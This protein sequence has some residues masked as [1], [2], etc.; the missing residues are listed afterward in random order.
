[1]R[2]ISFLVAVQQFLAKSEELL[3]MLN[4]L[5]SNIAGLDAEEDPR[6]ALRQ[7]VFLNAILQNEKAPIERV[8]KQRIVFFVQHITQWAANPH[9]QLPIQTES[10]KALSSVIGH[11]KDMYG[12]HWADILRATLELWER[13]PAK[14]DGWLSLLHASL[15]LFGTLRSLSE[16]EDAN[17]DLLD[18]WNERQPAAGEELVSVLKSLGAGRN[19]AHQPQRIVNELLA[20]QISK[21]RLR[22][23]EDLSELF[24]LIQ[25]QS[26]S[27]QKTA[28]A[29]LDVQI[30]A[31]QE[32]VSFDAALDKKAARLPEE[33]VSMILEV[34]FM[35]DLGK[36]DL[37]TE[38]PRALRAYLLSWLLVF[39]HFRNA[40]YKVKAD[41]SE[42]IKEGGYLTGLLDLLATF[43]GHS[44]GKV[45][46]ASKFDIVNYDSNLES[47]P[48]KDMQW[49]LV[50]LFYLSL[51]HMPS[52]T[53]SWWIECRSRQTVM[54]IETWTEKCFSPLIIADAL[55]SANEWANTQDASPDEQLIIKINHRAKEVAASYVVDEQ[56]MK[57][58]ISLPG[59]YPLQQA[60]VE[61]I[62]RVA[63]EEKKW[64]S[65]LTNCRGVITFSNGSIP[66][67]LSSWRKNVVGAL[68]GQT[69]CAICYSIIGADR[70]LPSKR[71]NTCKNLFHSSCLF[72]WFKSSNASTCP[73]CRNPFN[74]G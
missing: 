46:D 35:S 28:F 69:E 7:L 27:I 61:G 23:Y 65:W 70:Q 38:M 66:D 22:S 63:V 52:L 39:D 36:V 74:Y 73:L 19:D 57:M 53:K 55:E 5:I 31:K 24:S 14:T 12:S 47:L 18:A 56:T 43:L 54:S 15:K 13:P 59:A 48:E 41:Y 68:K 50:H 9:L 49:L 26:E 29:I 6:K 40:S 1:M 32:Q 20:R 51:K 37:Q 34:P 16:E 33:L 11:M 58:V 8:A 42:D 10:L 25:A 44:R 2:F 17:D 64:Q 4:G 3:G 60:R 72:K 45:V 62:S 30:P 67:G 21:T 71:C